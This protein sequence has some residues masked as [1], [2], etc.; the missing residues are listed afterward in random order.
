MLA[1]SHFPSHDQ[2][3]LQPVDAIVL[4]LLSLGWDWPRT[5]SYG[6]DQDFG[7]KR[8][9]LIISVSSRWFTL[10][11]VRAPGAAGMTYAV[12]G[13]LWRGVLSSGRFI[14]SAERRLQRRSRSRLCRPVPAAA[15][16]LLPLA[17]FDAVAVWLWCGG[18]R[19][20]IVAAAVFGFIFATLCLR[21]FGRDSQV[22]DIYRRVG[23]WY[24]RCEVIFLFMGVECWWR[25]SC[26]RDCRGALNHF[27]GSGSSVVAK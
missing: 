24:P 16:P 23:G 4:L 25:R 27:G 7:G 14:Q 13:S 15:L 1:L 10:S 18:K 9:P 19:M 22:L 11:H 2:L 8:F 21:R 12:V 17:A 20:S 6:V 26:T 5:A 3:G